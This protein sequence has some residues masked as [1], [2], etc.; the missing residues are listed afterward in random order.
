MD[1]GGNLTV[2]WQVMLTS[3]TVPFRQR[4]DLRELDAIAAALMGVRGSALATRWSIHTCQDTT[5]GTSSRRRRRP[6]ASLRVSVARWIAIANELVPN[7]LV[8]Y[9]LTHNVIVTEGLILTV[10]GVLKRR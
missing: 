5:P 1:N 6:L 10:C 9:R 2:Q 7:R 4:S 3:V 8:P